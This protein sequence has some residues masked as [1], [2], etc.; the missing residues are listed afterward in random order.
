MVRFLIQEQR[1]SINNAVKPESDLG[2]DIDI[3]LSNVL[4]TEYSIKT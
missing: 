4:Q 2:A 3:L 1:Q